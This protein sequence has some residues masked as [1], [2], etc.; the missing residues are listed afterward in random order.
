MSPWSVSIWAPSNLVH[1][2]VVPPF[3]FQEYDSD[4]MLKNFMPF[5]SG[6]KQCAGAEYARAFLSTFLHVLVMKYRYSRYPIRY[7]RLAK[8][9][10]ALGTWVN[11]SKAPR[12]LKV[13]L[14]LQPDQMDECEERQNST[15]PDPEI[16]RWLAHQDHG[17]TEVKICSCCLVWSQLCS[18][19]RNNSGH[20]LSNLP[21]YTISFFKK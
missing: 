1:L 7:Q 12:F 5:G 21:I 8:D 18:Y 11:Q 6:M 16:W 20:V 2:T 19:E 9:H 13:S 17:E 15:E 14:L 10:A 4:V 3:Q